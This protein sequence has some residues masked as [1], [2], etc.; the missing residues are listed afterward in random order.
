MNHFKQQLT[1]SQQEPNVECIP[2]LV[3]VE[4]YFVSSSWQATTVIMPI[5]LSHLG[6][7]MHIKEPGKLQIIG[8][9]VLMGPYLSPPPPPTSLLQKLMALVLQPLIQLGGWGQW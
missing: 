8:V 5:I 9:Q 7:Y 4:V 6:S 1:N 3:I 2:W